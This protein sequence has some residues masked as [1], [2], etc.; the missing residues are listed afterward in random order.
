MS[1]RLYVGNLS[2]DI[3]EDRLRE[4][5]AHAGGVERA[6]IVKD[7]MTG[8]SRGFG[9]VDMITEEDAECA[10]ADLNGTDA[11]GRVLRVAL[12]K[13]KSSVPVERA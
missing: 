8:V 13:P 5:F 9:F 11:M 7:R 3:S 12:A 1:R 10:I 2:F 4:L 6:E